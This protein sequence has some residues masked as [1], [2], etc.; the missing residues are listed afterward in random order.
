[1][2]SKQ[3]K[4]FKSTHVTVR[5]MEE[6]AKMIQKYMKGYLVVREK[7]YINF[8]INKNIMQKLSFFDK[9]INKEKRDL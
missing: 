2:I 5:N 9:M 7:E 3:W 8:K 1:M 6:A 4:K